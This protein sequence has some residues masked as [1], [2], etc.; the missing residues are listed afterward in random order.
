L[1][2]FKKNAKWKKNIVNLSEKV[3]L[4]DVFLYSILFLVNF[5][6]LL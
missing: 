3:S 2:N 1:N 5:T 6:K 4:L